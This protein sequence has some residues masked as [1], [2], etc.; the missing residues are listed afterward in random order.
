LINFVTTYPNVAL[1]KVCE[2]IDFTLDVA[3]DYLPILRDNIVDTILGN[4]ALGVASPQIGVNLRAFGV[5]KDPEISKTPT[6][7]DIQVYYNPE[8][9]LVSPSK[10][11]ALEGC[12]SFPGVSLLVTRPLSVTLR[13]YDIEGTEQVETAYGLKARA[14]QHEMDHLDGVLFI[15]RVSTLKKRFAL[16][17]LAKHSKK[18]GHKMLNTMRQAYARAMQLQQQ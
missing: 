9:I 14:I 7:D 3:K 2:S 6:K 17:E 1:T 8:V 5:L 18:K 11:D 12:L 15:D 13:Y 10:E 16:K 4:Y